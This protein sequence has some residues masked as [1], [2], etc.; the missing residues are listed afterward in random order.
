MVPVRL[1]FTV[2]KMQLTYRVQGTGPSPSRHVT[3]HVGVSVGNALVRLFRDILVMI[4]PH[5]EVGITL[6][7]KV[8]YRLLKY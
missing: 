7:K 4:A 6:K 3:S 2:V 8:C 5:E 1:R